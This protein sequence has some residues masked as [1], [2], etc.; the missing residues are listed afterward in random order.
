MNKQQLKLIRENLFLK[1]KIILQ[2]G[3]IPDSGN[4][5][6]KICYTT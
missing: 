3:V 5:D 6:P 4:I 2:G 1:F